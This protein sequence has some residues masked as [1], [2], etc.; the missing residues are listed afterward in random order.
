MN[1]NNV[2]DILLKKIPEFVSSPEFS[3]CK[4]NHD[5][6]Y[7]IIGRFAD[8]VIRL[9]KEKKNIETIFSFLEEMATSDDNT[10]DGNKIVELLMFGFLEHLN[11]KESYYEYLV[12]FFGIK[13]KQ[14]LQETIDHNN[15][16]ASI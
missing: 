3:E 9:S 14:R 11:P 16:L 4:D 10:T 7:V 13:T 8:F 12:S 1:L 5:L 15:M 6:P 2:V